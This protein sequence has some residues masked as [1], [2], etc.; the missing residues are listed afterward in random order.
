M[1]PQ[2]VGKAAIAAWRDLILPALAG[3]PA[4]R[5]WPFDGPL[6]ALLTPGS[7][8][9]AETYPGEIYGHLGITFGPGGKGA[10]A[11]RAG[12]GALLRDWASKLELTLDPP[13]QAAL[14]DGFGAA[15]GGDDPFDAAVGL[16]G[17]LNILRGGRPPGDPTAPVVRK[18]E[19]WILGQSLLP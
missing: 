16:I 7:A 1:G 4:P 10:Q 13:F 8:V 6:A 3:D 12:N 18:I 19:G 9:I 11:A 15:P 5:L 17:L 2:Q 14:D